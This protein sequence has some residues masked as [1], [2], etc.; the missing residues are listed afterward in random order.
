MTVMS[1]LQLAF[2]FLGALIKS[3]RQLALGNLALRQ[4]VAMRR[5]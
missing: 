5:Q 2:I 3:Q 4:Q 1:I